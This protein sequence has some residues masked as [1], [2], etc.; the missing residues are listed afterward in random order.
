VLLPTKEV[1]SSSHLE[2]DET[3]DWDGF[4]HGE[5]AIAPS[6][7]ATHLARTAT[8]RRCASWPGSASS[9]SSGR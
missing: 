5:N 3:V 4:P 2:R 6:P 1:S 8:R 9:H 7:L